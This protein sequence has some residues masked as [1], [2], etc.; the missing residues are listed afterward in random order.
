VT[1]IDRERRAALLA[2]KVGALVRD[3]TGVTPTPDVFTGGA[4]VMADGAAWCLVDD[5]PARSLGPALAWALRKD[6]SAL[7]VLAESDTGVLAR[8]AAGFA[9]DIGVYTV[10]GRTLL[11]ATAEVRPVPAE[12]DER[13]VDLAPLIVAGGAEP[14]VEHGVLAGEVRGLEVC[15]AVIDTFSGA[16][17]LEVGVGAHD[18]EAFAMLH[19]DVPPVEALAGVVDKVTPH[20]RLDA[21]P[22]PLNRLARER[23]VRWAIVHGDIDAAAVTGVTG[24]TM[25]EPPVPRRNLKDVAPCVMRTD[26][27]MVAVCST[28][29]DLDVV[30]FAVDAGASMIVLPAADAY[31]VTR[32]LAALASIT[33]HAF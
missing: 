29:V 5:D 20:R 1:T 24:W 28:G 31:P 15:R 25:A 32:D 17:R 8:R 3:H 7:R 22:H 11:P 12:V 9:F 2:V 16:A 30:P 10:D 14:S 27:G 13:V 26:G 6:A 33:L 4:A 18:R 23:L 19:G 21:S